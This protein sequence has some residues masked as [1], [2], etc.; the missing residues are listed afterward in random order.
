MVVFDLLLASLLALRLSP[1]L[2]RVPSESELSLRE[3]VGCCPT[4]RLL[5]LFIR[6]VIWT[7]IGLRCRSTFLASTSYSYSYLLY[8]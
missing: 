7:Q 4:S 3:A 6:E 5:F 1:V 8:D 2:N